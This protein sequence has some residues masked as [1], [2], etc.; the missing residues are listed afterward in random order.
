VLSK[1]VLVNFWASC[2]TRCIEE[3]PSLQ[4]LAELM[5]DKPFAV[6]GVKMDEGELRAKTMVQQLGIGFPVLI[7][8]DSAVFHRW[9]APC[10]RRPMCWTGRACSVM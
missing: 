4:P 10:C 2:C 3:M 5:R 1:V 9:G 6:L 8:K 7:D